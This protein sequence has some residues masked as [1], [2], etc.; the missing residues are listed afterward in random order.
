[1]S[2]E[3]IGSQEHWE[4]SVNADHDYKEAMEKEQSDNREQPDDRQQEE[5]YNELMELEHESNNP[6]MPTEEY[7]KHSVRI[8]YL[9]DKL[10]IK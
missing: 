5:L 8:S 10:S 2:K 7:E 1:M 9:R 3:Y 6:E 4:D